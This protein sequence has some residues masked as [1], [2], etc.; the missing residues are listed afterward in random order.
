MRSAPLGKR[1]LGAEVTNVSTNGFWL[2]IDEREVLT[3]FSDFPWFEAATIRQLSRVERP[4]PHHLY[5]P[6]LDV[7]LAVD[8][9]D[10]PARYPLV[11]KAR[12]NQRM[13]LRDPLDQPTCPCA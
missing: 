6:E 2:L 9:L 4:S 12:S 10:Y 1:T 5:W 3:S 7:D 11:S 8:S 13:Q